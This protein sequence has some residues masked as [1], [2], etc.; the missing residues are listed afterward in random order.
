MSKTKTTKKPAAPKAA[1][2]RKA[3]EAAPGKIEPEAD[4]TDAIAPGAVVGQTPAKKR[5]NKKADGD[6]KS[7]KLSAIDAAA[8]VLAAASEPMNCKALVEA[9]AAEGL[10]TS[11]G[12]K[13]PAAT[14]YS[15]ILR[16]IDTK[17][18]EARFIKTDRGLFKA[19]G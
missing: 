11:P 18:G 12:G 16:E 5:G 19:K 10:W 8:Q 9:M 13:T 17:G 7:K 6:A 2:S 14:L 1:K 4:V 15:S 3:A